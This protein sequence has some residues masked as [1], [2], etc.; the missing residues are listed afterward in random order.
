[1]Q[2]ETNRTIINDRING[3]LEKLIGRL[4]VLDEVCEDEEDKLFSGEGSLTFE[5]NMLKCS[6]EPI[7]HKVAQYVSSM[8]KNL[9]QIL[10]QTFCSCLMRSV[11]V[12]KGV[13]MCLENMLNMME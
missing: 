9:I 7:P 11:A 13:I 5:C 1:V 8:L 4:K 3:E 6:I 12:V 10:S 2:S